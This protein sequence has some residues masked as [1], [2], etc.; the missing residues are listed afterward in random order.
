MENNIQLSVVMSVFN[1]EKY[2]AEAID[3]V[4][5]QD[6]I[7]FEFIIVNDGST[8]GSLRIIQSYS[9]KRIVLVN[10]TNGGLSKA[11]NTGIR[12]ARSNLIARMDADDICLPGRFRRQIDFMKKHPDCV[13]LGTNA[14]YISEAGEDL[15]VPSVLLNDEEIKR[16]LPNSAFFHSSVV[17]RKDKFE[18]AGGYPEQIPHFVEDKVLW[19]KMAKLGLFFNLGSPLIK[20]RIVPNSITASKFASDRL[21]RVFWNLVNDNPVSQDDIDH[22]LQLK[23]KKIPNSLLW[24]NYFF[25]L[26]KIYLEYNFNRR[27]A[28]KYLFKSVVLNKINA[29]IYFNLFLVFMP[30]AFVV[31]WKKSRGIVV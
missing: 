14:C 8:D 22:V 18:L 23:S 25:R 9:D 10:K 7:D 16:Y 30:R 27:L 31:W 3:S 17:F 20:Y 1:G 12:I 29:K 4:L 13:V 24:S 15:F 6:F 28:L 19:N 2:I 5:N 21:E 26:G 11:L